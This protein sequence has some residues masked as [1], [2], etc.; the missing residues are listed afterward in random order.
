MHE[1]CAAALAGDRERAHAVNQRLDPLHR[2]LFLQSNPIPVKWGAAELG[3]C[4]RGIRLPL[5]WLSDQYHA[6]VRAAM[7]QA[8][9]L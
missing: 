9:L 4:Q 3:L 7:A 5:T 6:R 1:S 2:D 8:G